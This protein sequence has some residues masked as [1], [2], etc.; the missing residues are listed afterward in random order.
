MIEFHCTS[1]NKLLRTSDDKA[2]KRA[3]CPDCGEAIAIPAADS[4]GEFD[5][6]SFDVGDERFGEDPAQ[7]E[8]AA[9][10]KNCP[11]CGAQIR[12]AAIKCRHCGETLGTRGPSRRR[13]SR[14]L[15]SPQTSGQATASMILGIVSLASMCICGLISIPCGITAIILGFISLPKINSGE[16]V[17]KGQAIAGIIMGFFGLALTIG[18]VIFA[19][20]AQRW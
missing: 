2:G 9:G 5:L 12:A 3:R 15:S 11:M 1:C 7:G 17:G 14:G 6:G 18:F 13:R 4:G 10:M 8:T 16:S 19:L 20:A